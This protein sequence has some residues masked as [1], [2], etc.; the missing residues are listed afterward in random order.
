MIQGFLAV[1]KHADRITLLVEMMAASGC[2]CFKSK[3]AAVQGLKKRLSL[4]APEHQ[5]RAWGW[6]GG[7]EGVLHALGPTIS[8]PWRI[9]HHLGCAVSGEGG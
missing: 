1:R 8:P 6:M 4:T 9:I 2:P 3:V 7:F 5:V